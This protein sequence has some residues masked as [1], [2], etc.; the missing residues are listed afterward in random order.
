M[1][2]RD[3]PAAG[4][5][6]GEVLVRVAAAR[7]RF[8]RFVFVCEGGPRLARIP[9]LLGKRGIE[10]SVDEV[11][12]ALD[13]V[14]AALAKVAAGGSKGRTV[15]RIAKDCFCESKRGMSRKA[16]N[17]QRLGKRAPLVCNAHE[18]RLAAFRHA[19]RRQRPHMRDDDVAL[20]VGE[21]E[22]GLGVAQRSQGMVERMPAM[23]RLVPV[24]EEIVV[25]HRAANELGLAHAQTKGARPAKRRCRHPHDM[26]VG[27]HV[28]MLCVELHLGYT[29]LG[30]KLFEKALEALCRFEVIHP[31][32]TDSLHSRS[33]LHVHMCRCSVAECSGAGLPSPANR[34]NGTGAAA[35]A[36]SLAL[37]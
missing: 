35:Q 33:F 20:L 22:I 4:P 27:A 25:E 36:T 23:T 19:C 26:V 13:D 30:G 8:Y 29:A 16:P 37:R 7:S 2:L 21:G 31:Q 18:P 34:L 17:G 10:A 9:R 1:E 32:Q 14:N 6:A 11:V 3:I 12:F 5:G 28:A 15:L 24:V